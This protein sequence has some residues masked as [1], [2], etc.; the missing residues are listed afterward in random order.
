VSIRLS[1]QIMFKRSW[2]I[3]GT[4]VAAI[5]VVA[6]GIAI[7]PQAPK[8]IRIGYAISLSGPN[9]PGANTTTLPNYRLWVK[10]VNAAGGIMLKSIGKR[11]PI[12]VIAYDDHSEVDKAVEAVQHLIE[13]DKVDFLLSPQ[14]TSLNLAVGPLFYQAGYPHLA[15]TAMSDRAPELAK[16]WPN[17]FWFA[18]TITDAAGGLVATLDKLRSEGKVSNRV[19][20]VSVAD[21]LGIG[22]AKAARRALR[23]VS[24]L[25]LSARHN[26]AHR[27]GARLP[28]QPQ[29][30]LHCHRNRLPAF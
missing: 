17:S 14:G 28:L 6:A 21:Q 3:G 20:I 5:V 13:Q 9:A 7:W 24:C 29:S 19:A 23:F 27:A 11:L 16:L 18:G 26:G 10:E 25:Q 15:V 22:L 30:F 8:T 1:E 4:A 12:E 2:M